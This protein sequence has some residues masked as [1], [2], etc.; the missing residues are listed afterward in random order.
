MKRILVVTLLVGVVVL[1]DQ[2]R[3]Q[4]A[5]SPYGR[6]AVTPRNSQSI[7]VI[8]SVSFKSGYIPAECWYYKWI[9]SPF[10][11]DCWL[12]HHPT[13]AGAIKWLNPDSRLPT[14]TWP[15]WPDWRK[16]DLRKA[17]VAA[18]E[19]YAG[20]MVTYTGTH[21]NDVPANLEAPWAG[22]TVLDE[23]TAAWPIYV[24]HVAFSLAAE[25]RSWVPWS[26]RAYD[27]A[28][29][30]DLFRANPG[31]FSITKPPFTVST[32]YAVWGSVTPTHPAVT[33]EFLVQNGMIGGTPRATIARVLDWARWNMRHMMGHGNS[34]DI[35]MYVQYIGKTPMAR[36]LSGTISTDPT[37]NDPNV[38][39]WTPGCYGTTDFLVWLLR[40]AN[41]PVRSRSDA[42]TCIHTMPF[43]SAEKLYLSHGDDPYNAL[44]HSAAPAGLLLV[45]QPTWHA[46]FETGNQ[47]TSCNNV[48]R[49][50][51]EISLRYFSAT[52]VGKYCAD[53]L[54]GLDH[55]S[56]EVYALYSEV[57]T[58][59]E[60]E[61]INLWTRLA[62][63]VPTSTAF[64]CAP[65]Q[66][67]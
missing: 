40:V 13:I 60:L 34:D 37:L 26:L 61:A 5:H 67:P 29:L 7:T 25:I 51:K 10:L 41:I 12:E 4:V 59:A 45:D 43:F 64:Q 55:A 62:A 44:M 23:D 66:Q 18:S 32:G 53:T 42:S 27:A 3:A 52:L 48:G 19:W 65:L 16:D 24:A 31:M 1:G 14:T 33:L 11:L 54:N 2:P 21:V 17:Y 47:T 30:A 49:R 46:W 15:D 36:M 6:A 35:A 9:D 38:H 8:P 56:G 58:V 63:A 57:Y 28:E 20:G 39:H 22:P 50:N